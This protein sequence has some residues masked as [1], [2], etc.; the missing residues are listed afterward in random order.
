MSWI[1]ALAVLLYFLSG[2]AQLP[3]PSYIGS[4]R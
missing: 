3:T 2:N 1:A 4:N